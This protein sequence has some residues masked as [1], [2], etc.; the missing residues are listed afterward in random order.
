MSAE[1]TRAIV[2]RRTNYGEADRILTL[3][4]PQGQRSVIARGARR[5]KS[6]LAGGI[7][8]FTISD[9]VIQQ[10]K[11][12]LGILSQVRMIKFYGHILEDY[13][14]LQFAYAAIGAIVKASQHVDEP[15]WFGVLSEV[16]MGL[17]VPTIPLQLVESWFYLH[18]AE[19]MGYELNLR[20]DMSGNPLEPGKK[21]RYDV[22]ERGLRAAEQGDVTADH[23]KILRLLATRPIGTIVQVGGLEALLPDVWL[24]ARQHA[25]I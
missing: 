12:D 19:L 4:T 6:K 5:E 15:E 13:D 25:A 14:R 7:E 9:V 22:S 3:L 11:G 20:A 21:Y 24:L 18:Y 8:L 16:Y 23:I 10:G 17:D 2:L 1:R